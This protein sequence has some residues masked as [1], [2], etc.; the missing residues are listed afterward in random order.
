M[1]M[2]LSV[3]FSSMVLGGGAVLLWCWCCGGAVLLWCWCCGGAVL[4]WVVS[5]GSTTRTDG[6]DHPD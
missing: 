2:A 4:L 1:Y 6:L 5:T 3:E